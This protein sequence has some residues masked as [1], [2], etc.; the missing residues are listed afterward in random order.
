MPIVQINTYNGTTGVMTYT[1]SNTETTVLLEKSLNYGATWSSGQPFGTPYPITN[2]FA[3]QDTMFRLRLYNGTL[4]NVYDYRVPLPFE[5][6]RTSIASESQITFANSPIHCRIQ[7]AAKNNTIRKIKLKLWIWSGSQNKVLGDPNVTFEKDIISA[8]DTYISL[9]ISDKIKAYIEQ[10]TLSSNNLQPQ[11]GYNVND[12]PAIS[13]QGVFW[14]TYTEITSTTG[15]EFQ[16]SDTNF[17]TLGWLWNYEQNGNVNPITKHGSLG[18]NM[19]VVKYFNPNVPKY[20]KQDFVLGQ[21]IEVATSTNMI[22]I[23]VEEKTLTRCTRDSSLIVYLDKRG[24][25]DVFTPHGKI[26]VG[27]KPESQLSKRVFRDPA[28]VNNTTAH[29]RTRNSLKVEQNY[30]VNTG[31]ID[32]SDV[33]RVEELIY[34]P[35]IYFIKF[36]G[37]IVT[38]ITDGITIDST[39][40][41]IDN[42]EITIDNTPINP[43]QVP[44]FATF[45][46]IPVTVEDN[47]FIRKTLMNNKTEIDYN[48]QLNE[49]NNKINSV[50]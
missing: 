37:D 11:F 41:T 28:K 12:L 26:V 13:G 32:E 35:K 33:Q 31:K 19:P 17:A 18:F 23:E 27:A 25:W 40:I 50:R 10:P 2:L 3:V 7:N 15:T 5:L 34:S 45:Q 39:F 14:Q 8:N 16:M 6:I 24:L 29:S 22:S 46:Q 30:I 1:V 9:E 48:I 36:L 38:T 4:S 47:D 43:T 49:T 44:Y 42:D 20:F 21:S